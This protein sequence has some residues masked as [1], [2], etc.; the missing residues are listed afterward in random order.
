M[1]E[2]QRSQRGWCRVSKKKGVEDEL[3]EG[4]GKLHHVDSLGHRK[5]LDCSRME[6]YGQF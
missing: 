6:S 5:D 1:Q 3:S 2:Q 4:E